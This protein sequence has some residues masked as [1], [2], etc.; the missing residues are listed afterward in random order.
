M[1]Y[2]KVVMALS[3]ERFCMLLAL[4]SV[5]TIAVS[6]NITFLLLDFCCLLNKL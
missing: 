3:L 2:D 4:I 5:H 6:F 1:G